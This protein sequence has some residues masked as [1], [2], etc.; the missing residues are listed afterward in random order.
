MIPVQD[1]LH[2]VQWDPAWRGGL[3][4]V[5]YLDRVVGAVVRV[6]LAGL[7]LD[8][9]ATPALTL[10]DG[11]G[12]VLRIPLHRVRV[13]WRDGAVIWRRPPAR[14]PGRGAA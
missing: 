5:G 6:P 2:R 12:A 3:F 7:R 10:R 13:V 14:T 8:P 1:V 4:E 9:G 11:E